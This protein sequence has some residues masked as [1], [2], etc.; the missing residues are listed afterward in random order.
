ME[1]RACLSQ[2]LLATVVLGLA[3]F[4]IT[5]TTLAQSYP[6]RPIRLIIGAS[7]GGASDAFAR[8]VSPGL[9]ELLGQQIV[10]DNRP[11]ANGNI[12]IE[13]VARAQPD[14]YTLLWGVSTTLVIN[15]SLYKHPPID[16]QKDFAPIL[17]LGS[18]QL[19]LVVHRSVQANSVQELIALVK[20][21]KPGQF[22]YASGGIGSPN[23][24]AA[25][26]L[27]ART[28]LNIIHVP[29]KGGGPATIAALSGE[30][31]IFFASLA[32][33]VPHIKAGSLKALAVTAPKRSSEAP[34][35]PTMQESGFPG[36][37]VRSWHGVLAPA[38]TPKPIV[39]H[40]GSDLTKVM[41]VP[42]VQE[43]LKRAGL[44][45]SIGTPEDFAAYIKSE[46]ALWTKVIKE[47]GIRAD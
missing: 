35:T 4:A 24:L 37:D 43:A 22:Q 9:A 38:G 39:A 13:L 19:I 28:G 14:G 32:S 15:P 3:T 21:S 31:N 45:Q 11:G 25:A 26:L 1:S 46:T 16:P 7:P 6:S 27:I 40:L 44:E 8:I 20:S 12:A 47:A 34:D 41:S 17:L 36:F 2:T 29:Y 18:Q 30:T 5:N 33:A 10:I 42:N 23:H